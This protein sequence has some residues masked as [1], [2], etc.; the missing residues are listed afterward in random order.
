MSKLEATVIV[1][2]DKKTPPL[3]INYLNRQLIAYI[4]NKRRLLPFLF[5]VFSTLSQKATI[6]KFLDPFAG[7][8]A[9]SRL[10]KYMGYSV[11]TND[12][13]PY[14]EIVNFCY[15]CIHRYELE[16]LFREKGGVAAVFTTINNLQTEVEP[17][18]SRYYAP[19]NTEK[20][21]YRKERL[22]YTHENALFI[23][24]VREWIEQQYPG[25]MPGQRERK[26]KYLLLSS[27]LYEAAT[28]VNTSGVFKA[29]HKG[30][31]GHGKDALSRIKAGAEMEIPYLLNRDAF[32]SV[33][34][35]D[36]GDFVRGKSADLCYLDPPYNQHQYG[37]NYHLLNTIALWDKPPVSS[38]LG[39]DGKLKDKAGIR[40][41]WA[42]TKSDFCYSSTAA[43][44]FT[45][46]MDGID[47]R[48]IA[49]SY[50][51]EGII[52]FENLCDILSRQG[53]LQLFCED[54]IL[55]R[56]GKQSIN[57]KDY[58]LEFILVLNRKE[59]PG[60]GDFLDIRRFIL[61]RKIVSLC[62]A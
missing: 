25:G 20:A 15:I 4:G 10:A 56:G 35:M 2:T 62:K 54:Y 46:L 17:Y 28:H 50:N 45:E 16:D 9:V 24:R 26:E 18:I 42:V 36:A 51:T 61:E 7:S 23:D 59:K 3:S 38:G 55:F 12:W 44:A 22:F 27:L 1:S 14:A 33:S 39:P 31:G 29:C 13:E 21:D 32:C 30:F 53:S 47:A 40:K 48:F 37:S 5:Q 11:A 34:K 60:K 41:N 58:N 57:R 43:R 49:L 52:P 19:E 8:G 6:G